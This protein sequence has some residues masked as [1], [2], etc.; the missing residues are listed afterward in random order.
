MKWISK[1]LIALLVLFNASSFGANVGITT[2]YGKTGGILGKL[3]T[4]GDKVNGRD[5]CPANPT[6][7][8]DFA[9][10]PGYSNNNTVDDPSDDSYSGDLLVRTNDLFQVVAGWNWSGTAGSEEEVKLTGTLPLKDGKAYYEWSALPGS[11]D[12][13]KS[14]ISDDKQTIV[15]VRK[16][17]DKNDVGTYAEDLTFNVRVRGGTPNGAT[18]GDISFDIEGTNAT[19]KSDGT[20]GNSLTVTAAPRWNL[21]KSQYTRWAGKEYNGK[22]GWIVDYYFYIES[23]EVNGETDDVNPIVGNESMG[24]DTT[25]TFTDD[26]SSLTPNT[27]LMECRTSG[28]YDHKDGYVGSTNPLTCTGD[29]CIY[30]SDPKYADRQILSPKGKQEISCNKNGDKIAITLKHVDATLNHYPTKDYAGRDLPKN[31]AIAAIGS[32]TMFVPVDDVKIGK[33]GVDDNCSH[34]DDSSCDDGYFPI[35]NKLTDFDPTTPSGNSNFGDNTESEK[36]NSYAQTLYYASGSWSKRFRGGG[37]TNYN[38]NDG[39]DYVYG[40]TGSD[41]LSG[42]G[43]VTKGAEFSTWLVTSNSGGTPFSEDTTCDVFDAYRM[44]LQPVG[45]NNIYTN[46]RKRYT[47]NDSLPYRYFIYGDEGNYTDGVTHE[48]DNSNGPEI[49]YIVEY[50]TGYVDDSFLPSKGGDTTVEHSADIQRECTDGSVNWTT[51]FNS[52]KDA[53]GGLGATKVRIRLKPGVE[54]PPGG[55]IYIW[56]N[57]KV[58]DTDLATNQPIESGALIVNYAGHKFNYNNQYWPS[59]IPGTYPGTHS[60]LGGDR[61]IVTGPKVRIKKS[62]N[63]TAASPG[64]EIT[65]TLQSSYTN[66]TETDES[67]EVRIVDVLPKDFKYKKGSVAPADEFG[68]PYIGDCSDVTDLNVTCEDGKNQVLIWDLGTRAVNSPKIPDLNYTVLVGAAAKTGVNTNHVKIESPTDASP[69]TQR[70]ADIGVTIDVPSSINIVKTTE[71][72]SDY[73]S[74]RE[75]TTEFKDI[76]FN[77]D[78]RNGTS[79]NL[80]D[81]DV[82]DILPFKGDGDEKAIKFNDLELKRKVPTDYHGSMKFSSADFMQN[83]NSDKVCGN[84]DS[85]KYYYTKADP[86]TINMA[87]SVGEENDLNSNKSIWCEGDKNG[88]NGCQVNGETLTNENVTAIRVRGA[89]M[90]GQAICQFK[91]NIAVKDNLAGDNYSNSAGASATGVTL[92]VLSNSLA[93]PIVGSSLGDYVWYDKNKNGIQ[94]E[95]EKGIEGVVVH[96]LDDSGNPVNKPGTNNPYVVTTD[97]NGK[98]IFDKLNHGDY[99]VKFDIPTGYAISPSG[100]TDDAKDSDADSSGIAQ[101]ILGVD[102]HNMNVD[103]GINT[104]IISGHIFDD[105][106]GDGNINGAPISKAD[107]TQLYVTLLDKDGN[108]IA[109]K[110]VNSDGTYEFDGEDGVRADSNYKVVLSKEQNATSGSLPTN[111]NNADGEK[112]SNSG[113]GNDGSADGVLAVS[114]AK[115]DVPN[116]DLGINKKPVATDVSKPSELNPGGDTQVQVPNLNV[117]DTED[118]KPT[119]ITIKDLPANATLYYNGTA[120]TAGQVIPNFDPT[121]L[122]VDPIDGDQTVVFHYTTT[123][124]AGVESEPATVTMP[125]TGVTLS[126]HVFDDGNGDTNINGTPINKPDG[127]PLFATLVD[128]DGKVIKSIPVADDGTYSF[129][130][131]DGVTANTEYSLVLSTAEGVAGQDAPTPALPTNWNNADGEQPNNSGAG[132][133]G[134]VNGA[135]DGKMTLTTGSTATNPNNDFGINHKPVANDT[136]KPVQL[137]PGGATQVQV[138]DLNVTDTEDGKPTTITIKDLPANATLYYNGTAVTAGQVIPNFDPT[139]L[140]V[141]PIDGDQTVVFHYTT[142]D[143]AGVESEP[144][145]VTMPFSG[146]GISGHLFDDGNGDGNVNGAPVN[147]PDGK[148]LYVNLLDEQGNVIAVKPLADDGTYVFT[149]TDGVTANTKYKLVLSTN[150]G[151]IGDPAPSAD[152]PTNWN[153]TGE[154]LNDTNATGND[155]AADGTIEVTLGTTNIPKI[156]FGINKKPVAEDASKPAQSNP[157][158]DTKYLVPNMQISDHEDGTPTTVTIKTL[159]DPATGTLYYDGQPV[160]AGQE[161]PNFDPSKLMV[162]PEDGNQNVVFTYTTTDN[163]GVESDLATVTMSFLGEMHLGD[164]VWMDDNGNGAQ[165]LGEKGVA[166][167]TVTLLDENGSV[168]GTTTTDA[169]GKYEFVIKEPGKY[170]V[171]FDDAYYYTKKCDTCPKDKDSNVH[172]QNSS[173]ELIEMDWGDTNMTVDAGI[174]PTAHIGDYFWIDANADGVQDP[175]EK[176]VVGAKV[177]LLDE[178]G[179]PVLDTD[180]NPIVQTTDENGKY[181]FDVPAG[182]KYKVRFTIPDKYL[183]DG[184]IF[185][186]GDTDNQADDSDAGSNG[187]STVLVDA[188]EGASILTLDAGIN[189]ACANIKS[190]SGDALSLTTFATMIMMLIGMIA[191]FNK[192]EGKI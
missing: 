148:Q 162:D 139:K 88:P 136:S 81:L 130:G 101:K 184:Y 14:S 85:I 142:T 53:N 4:V 114:V 52:I 78:L 76:K 95:G 66:D 128:K 38:G 118:G 29:G 141:D 15:C 110:P 160:T 143:A 6:A 62:E 109:T 92:P 191:L 189:C 144:A 188:T 116:N 40:W 60:G 39:L 70:R 190:D 149:G 16:D 44:K 33:N 69:I 131:A 171:K 174:T 140:T 86:K 151:T 67:G 82:I 153:N 183:D 34:A 63:R 59:Y 27:E 79:N 9:D 64:S 100:A 126:G 28:R 181:G 46:I 37:R 123:D 127:T 163:A 74:L 103:L 112:P 176:P 165:D 178:N 175:D 36:D 21:Q 43:M 157:S 179:N 42:D 47:G 50:A 5:I 22:K 166:G 106:N 96:L 173:T 105:G 75:R 146:L 30:G 48:G 56:L 169:N 18:P 134:Q 90:E 19:K 68:E 158:G 23:D 84:L 61:V 97:A 65:Y 71:E 17:F 7:G 72:N 99:K 2:K 1:A 8:C 104:P 172:G 32:I 111:W 45:E 77:L 80:T 159:P 187:V 122:T 35:T 150:Q 125:F 49:P 41:S 73:P 26:M 102:E 168:V 55:G 51:D 135:G 107:D 180:G 12:L 13:S 108:A 138:P 167:V 120:V 57:H 54:V 177:E 124:A 170:K 121:K 115:V 152:L 182:R 89:S 156:D 11:C 87:P 133:D 58:R 20:D 31:R 10:D 94:D 164:T 185:T 91:V 117:T 147:K 161:I 3:N 192:R 25:F 119:T 186:K 145:T 93:V 154:N 98:Y 24:E 83:P 113:S 132:N 137:N 129:S 155:G